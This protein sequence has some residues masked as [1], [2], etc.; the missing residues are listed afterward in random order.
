V[1]AKGNRGKVTK[2]FDI[3]STSLLT[4]TVSVVIDFDPA[5]EEEKLNNM[6]V[7]KKV[8]GP[9]IEI[10]HTLDSSVCA[11]GWCTQATISFQLDDDVTLTAIVPADTDS[12]GVY[13]QFDLNDDGDFDD[14]DEL[15]NC[16]LVPNPLQENHDGDRAGDACDCD[17]DND[18]TPDGQEIRY[19]TDPFNRNQYKPRDTGDPDN[20]GGKTWEEFWCGTD[21]DD[22]CGD[23]CDPDPPYG[24]D[25]AW[26]FDLNI[27]CWV[28][29][30]DILAF[31]QNINMPIQQGVINPKPFQCR[32]DVAPDAWI[33]SSDIIRFSQR[34]SMPTS[35]T[36]P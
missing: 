2:K 35:C 8:T 9:S 15:D 29:S 30:S 14:P 32:Y 6:R 28:N 1:T 24:T 26:L 25:D 33:N 7:T 4:G 3:V 27:S 5:V 12:D 10:T 36:N 16:A 19:G 11:G 18:G 22:E 23:D 21:P 13:D 17:D 20:D 34:L 31:S